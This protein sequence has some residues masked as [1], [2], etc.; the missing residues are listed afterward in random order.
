MDAAQRLAGW[1]E[2]VVEQMLRPTGDFPRELFTQQ[3]L[4]SIAGTVSWHWVN[5]DG[6]FGFQ[7][8][9]PGP[10]HPHQQLNVTYLAVD[11]D[12]KALILSKAGVPANNGPELTAR[13]TA[14]LKLLAQGET[15]EGIGRHLGISH[16]TVEAHLTH[17]YRKLDVRDRLQAVLVAHELGLVTSES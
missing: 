8:S 16:R 7:L 15:A 4:E 6:S 12:L 3:L 17:L 9:H 5:D 14:V 13:E 10:G 11:G 2:L 1:L